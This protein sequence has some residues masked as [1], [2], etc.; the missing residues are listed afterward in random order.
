MYTLT[1]SLGLGPAYAAT[2]DLRA[3]VVDTAGA[4]V[5]SAISTGFVNIGSGFH[6]WNYASMPDDQRGGV[7]FYS[8]AATSTMLG[9]VSVNPQE[10]E[11][12]DVKTSTRGTSTL[13]TTD[14]DNRLV[15][16]DGATQADLTATQAA[17]SAAITALNN[18]SSAQA[19]TAAEAALTTY[20]PPTKAEL[21]TAQT[22]IIAAIPSAASAASA[23]MA[24]VLESGKSF[25]VAML[26]IWAVIVGDSIADNAN[27]PTAITYD[28]PDSSVQITHTLTST[29]RTVA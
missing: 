12:T 22:A 11:Y 25:Q 10:A 20:D 27:D 6:L 23:V 17:I 26:D 29:T 16:Y 14:I 8:N 2:S 24:Y 28:S 18:L 1:F 13:T 7:K 19:Q 5:G 3:Q 21:D 15:A 4:N 9:F